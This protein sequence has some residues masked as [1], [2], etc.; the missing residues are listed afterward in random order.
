MELF[1]LMDGV[2]LIDMVEARES[3]G[4]LD[5]AEADDLAAEL[6]LIDLEERYAE[7]AWYWECS[8]RY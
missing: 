6:A 8:G 1:E 5:G 2:E 7:D 3:F 4:T